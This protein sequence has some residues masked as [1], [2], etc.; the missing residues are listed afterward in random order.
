MGSKFLKKRAAESFL[1]LYLTTHL[2]VMLRILML[3][4]AE[5]EI[6]PFGNRDEAVL[7][8]EKDL[9]A[10]PEMSKDVGRVLG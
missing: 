4:D 10:M 5:A 7:S 1:Q 6:V 2:L 3:A 9:R 8:V